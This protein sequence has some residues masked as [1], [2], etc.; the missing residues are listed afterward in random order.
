[1]AQQ[2]D[3]QRIAAYENSVQVLTKQ[4]ESQARRADRWRFMAVGAAVVA[5]VVWAKRKR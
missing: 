5:A 4:V 3:A 1:M 2:T